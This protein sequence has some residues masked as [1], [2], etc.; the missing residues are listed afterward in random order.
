VGVGRTLKSGG[1]TCPRAGRGR[2][3]VLKHGGEKG[4]PSHKKGVTPLMI[5][6]V[7]NI[8]ESIWKGVL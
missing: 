1:V 2:K 7:F 5:P 3:V 4:N 6:G 8:N